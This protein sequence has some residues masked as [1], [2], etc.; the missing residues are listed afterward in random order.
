MK[1]PILPPLSVYMQQLSQPIQ[2]TA[3]ELAQQQERR[4]AELCTAFLYPLHALS[5]YVREQPA[6]PELVL[7]IQD[8]Y[9]NQKR[10][11]PVQP[12]LVSAGFA[13]WREQFNRSPRLRERLATCLQTCAPELLA[14]AEQPA[15]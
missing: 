15:D 10:K 3:Q 7:V 9:T 2:Y 1:D 12:I 5:A 13:E 8:V 6:G 11:N 4:R 14:D